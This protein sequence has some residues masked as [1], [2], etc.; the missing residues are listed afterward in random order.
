MYRAGRPP[1]SVNGAF[2]CRSSS[3]IVG[4]SPTSELEV[5]FTDSCN[6]V[7]MS[8]DSFD[9]E[10]CSDRT[11]KRLCMEGDSLDNNHTL[12]NDSSLH[13]SMPTIISD[14][15]Q[16]PI[17]LAGSSSGVVTKTF[18]IKNNGGSSSSGVISSV[19]LSHPIN[20][21]TARIFGDGYILQWLDPHGVFV[22]T[23][24][25]SDGNNLIC[26]TNDEEVMCIEHSCIRSV[27]EG[28]STHHQLDEM[29]KTNDYMDRGFH[30]VVL[31]RS[32]SSPST[33]NYIAADD[34]EL[35]QLISGLRTFIE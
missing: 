17:M 27:N 3:R 20:H 11:N 19:D 21:F 6:V 5:S 13:P 10:E 2:A 14:L 16:S 9:I 26:R 35:L 33:L 29:C 18:T 23:D 25:V 8:R 32:S 24:L 34:Q 12:G 30:I 22:S 1:L 31:H 28:I 4:E 15:E 7:G